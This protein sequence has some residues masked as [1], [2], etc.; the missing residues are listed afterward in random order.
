WELPDAKAETDH[1]V[2]GAAAGNKRVTDD[3]AKV[4]GPGIGVAVDGT[5]VI[6]PIR[7]RP[8]WNSRQRKKENCEP[9]DTR[10]HESLLPDEWSFSRD[11]LFCPLTSNQSNPALLCWRHFSTSSA[12][13]PE[14]EQSSP[15]RIPGDQHLPY[16]ETIVSHKPGGPGSRPSFGR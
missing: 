9:G 12:D 15:C 3:V 5:V 4:D 10:F 11:F 7:V 16:T 2:V 13:V 1:I 6:R 8:G 14:M